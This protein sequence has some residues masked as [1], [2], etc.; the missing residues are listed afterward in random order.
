MLRGSSPIQLSQLDISPAIQA[1]ALEQQA[2]AT[3]AAGIDQGI[4]NFESKREEKK[5]RQMTASL[6]KQYLPEGTTDDAI[7][8]LAS[9][10]DLRNNFF[11]FL[12]A[13]SM[14]QAERDA[15][16]FEATQLSPRIEAEIFD[17]NIKP[18]IGNAAE[19]RENLDRANEG[20]NLL[21]KGLETGFGES[22]K[23]DLKK[24][25]NNFL[26]TD[27]D[28]ADQEVFRSQIEPLMQTYIQNTKGSISDSEMRLFESWSAGLSNTA[29][30]NLRIL[31][32]VKNAADRQLKV[33]NYYSQLLTETNDVRIINLKLEE[34]INK[35][36][37]ENP[38]FESEAANNKQPSSP[39]PV[40]LIT[41]QEEYDEL[42][43]GS[44]FRETPDGQVF[45]KP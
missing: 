27:F 39:S 32:A 10:K 1:S 4:K 33:N 12:G 24:F 25:A 22:I 3:L 19:A 14:A 18:K 40:M 2:A 26:G 21:N 11:D 36:A 38:I 8:A 42:P 41:T 20:I 31:K 13:Q 45:V 16:A 30:S 6:L 35:E 29:E 23:L 37:S 15:A 5:Q 43:S 28:V 44:R 9:D 17:T 7:N 34:F